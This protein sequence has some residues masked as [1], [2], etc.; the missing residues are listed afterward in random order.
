MFA[1]QI[2]S[3]V[4]WSLIA[5]VIMA[6]ATFGMWLDTRKQRKVSVE[7]PVDIRVV[8][9]LHQQFASKLEFQQ[10]V[11]DTDKQRGLLHKRM[12]E[13]IR[14]YNEKFQSLPNE[15]VAL[16]RNTGNLK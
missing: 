10:H 11:R 16:L 12:D 14:D 3:D 13:A 15:I 6:I 8:E 5:T 7:Q 1:E 4:N 9:Q 2:A